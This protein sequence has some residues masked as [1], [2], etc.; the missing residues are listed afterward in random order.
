[1]A[2]TKNIKKPNVTPKASEIEVKESEE[3]KVNEDVI[4]EGS[5]ETVENSSDVKN[6]TSEEVTINEDDTVAVPKDKMV[7]IRPRESHRCTIGGVTYDLKKDVVTT[8]PEFVKSVLKKADL[9]QSL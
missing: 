3:V 5:A 7:K 8:V 9:L 4:N 1:M 6:T 2:A